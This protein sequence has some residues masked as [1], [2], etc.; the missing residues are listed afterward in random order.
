VK[1][2]RPRAVALAVAYDDER[3]RYDL[4]EAVEVL[5]NHHG[6]NIGLDLVAADDGACRATA[7][8]M[9]SGQFTVGANSWVYSTE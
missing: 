5:G 9:H 6:R 8:G 3:T 2:H 1:W 4:E 7:T